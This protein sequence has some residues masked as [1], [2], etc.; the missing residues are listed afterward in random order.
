MA[1]SSEDCSSFEANEVDMDVF[2][3]SISG[4]QF[5]LDD[6]SSVLIALNCPSL[7]DVD[8]EVLEMFKAGLVDAVSLP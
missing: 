5:Q 7:E 2:E 8:I 1:C 4:L 6:S 3:N